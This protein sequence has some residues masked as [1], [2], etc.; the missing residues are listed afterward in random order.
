VVQPQGIRRAQGSGTAWRCRLESPFAGARLIRYGAGKQA[1]RNRS[2]PI[3]L[4][5]RAGLVIFEALLAS[6]HILS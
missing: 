1:R 6:C 2:V 5:S 4:F 3:W